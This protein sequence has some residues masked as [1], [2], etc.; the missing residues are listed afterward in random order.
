M[1]GLRTPRQRAPVH[2]REVLL[3]EFLKPYGLSKR[4]LARGLRLSYARVL[5]LLRGQ[6]RV[7][8][9]LALRLARYFGTSPEFWLNLQLAYDLYQ[10]E[11]K[12]DYREIEPFRPPAA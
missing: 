6:S 3:E 5:R 1:L 9:D 7:T 4:G 8:P 11:A 12:G 2:P 10:A